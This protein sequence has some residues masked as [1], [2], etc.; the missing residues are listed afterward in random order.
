MEGTAGAPLMAIVDC[1]DGEA[2]LEGAA[3]Q[4][5]DRMLA[6]IGLDRASICL[7]T[8]TSARPLAGRIG[9][10]L[11]AQLAPVVRHHIVLAAPKRLLIMGAA[12][13][14]A[15]LGADGA[16]RRGSLQRVNLNPGTVEAVAILPPGTLIAQPRG[17]AEAWRGLQ[18]LIGG[19]P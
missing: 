3:S 18:S 4:L 1:P 14:R 15:L 11:E 12:A 16:A 8:F 10:E 9:P 6:A 17:K 13:S 7:A 5:F 19:K 2:I